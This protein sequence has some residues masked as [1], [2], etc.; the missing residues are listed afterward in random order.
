M[1]NRNGERK[2]S[3]NN[4][5]VFKV[6]VDQRGKVH[7][8]RRAQIGVVPWGYHYGGVRGTGGLAG[9]MLDDS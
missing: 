8:S 6:S 5:I 4:L 1:V 9:Q 7:D 2:E 3:G